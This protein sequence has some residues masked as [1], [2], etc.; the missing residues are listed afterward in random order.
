MSKVHEIE[1][2]RKKAQFEHETKVAQNE[3]AMREQEKE[4]E[5]K[6][7]VQR[8]RAMNKYKELEEKEKWIRQEIERFSKVQASGKKGDNKMGETIKNL[9]Q[10]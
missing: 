1:E 8:E 3:A 6:R 9:K 4:M 7:K 5:V 10:K 2:L